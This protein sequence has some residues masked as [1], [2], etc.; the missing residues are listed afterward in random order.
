M[1]SPTSRRSPRGS[2]AA[3]GK[4]KRPKGRSKPSGGCG[5]AGDRGGGRRREEVRPTADTR[6]MTKEGSHVRIERSWG[7]PGQVRR[8]RG[9]GRGA[10]LARQ[11]VEAGRRPGSGSRPRLL[12]RPL[13]L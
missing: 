7:S 4:K 1:A 13:P 10:R 5:A 8:S 9:R 3:G 11:E 2:N 12:D 6:E